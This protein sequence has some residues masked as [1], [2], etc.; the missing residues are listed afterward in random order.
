MGHRKFNFILPNW[1]DNDTYYLM[2]VKEGGMEVEERQVSAGFLLKCWE[3]ED[4]KAAQAAKSKY[5][6]DF[7][8]SNFNPWFLIPTYS[9]MGSVLYFNEPDSLEMSSKL[10]NLADDINTYTHCL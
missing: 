9:T 1:L 5:L 8:V 10:D 6:S 2:R 3:L 4:L 7:I